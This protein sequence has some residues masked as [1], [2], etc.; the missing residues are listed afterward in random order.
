MSTEWTD[1]IVH[2]HSFK[3]AYISWHKKYGAYKDS[4]V[5]LGVYA[6]TRNVN[7]FSSIHDLDDNDNAIYEWLK[8]WGHEHFTITTPVYVYHR[9]ASYRCYGVSNSSVNSLVLI[10][11]YEDLLSQLIDDGCYTVGTGLTLALAMHRLGFFSAQS[12]T[13]ALIRFMD[14]EPWYAELPLEYHDLYLNHL[15]PQIADHPYLYACTGPDVAHIDVTSYLLR[16][17]NVPSHIT[18]VITTTKHLYTTPFVAGLPHMTAQHMQLLDFNSMFSVPESEEGDTMTIDVMGL[19]QNVLRNK[20][21]WKWWLRHQ[22][23]ALDKILKSFE[24]LDDAVTFTLKRLFKLYRKGSNRRVRHIWKGIF[25]RVDTKTM[26]TWLHKYLMLRYIKTA[27]KRHGVYLATCW[28]PY[29][30]IAFIKDLLAFYKDDFDL[31]AARRLSIITPYDEAMHNIFV[32]DGANHD[33]A[34][35]VNVSNSIIRLMSKFKLTSSVGV[36]YSLLKKQITD[37]LC[38]LRTAFMTPTLNVSENAGATIWLILQDY[39]EDHREN[40]VL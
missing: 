40:L 33:N 26:Q 37:R 13:R 21:T 11:P 18:Q 5:G 7:L 24:C 32:S 28:I 25:A 12:M 1:I 14:G 4:V 16:T 39:L 20:R 31:Y 3:H 10:N 8:Q 23:T 34:Q 6:F 9:N 15:I 27:L 35:T 22:D 36:F 19:F 17:Y 2:D 38:V 30:P 29:P